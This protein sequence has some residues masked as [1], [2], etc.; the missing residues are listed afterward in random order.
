MPLAVNTQTLR[1]LQP[2]EMGSRIIIAQDVHTK[3]L[4][5]ATPIPL[6]LVLSSSQTHQQLVRWPAKYMRAVSPLLPSPHARKG[7]L[8]SPQAAQGIKPD[9]TVLL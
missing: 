2:T 3:F 8:D 5:P 6:T 7:G 9:L 1:L 4:N